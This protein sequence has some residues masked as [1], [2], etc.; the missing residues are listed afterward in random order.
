MNRRQRARLKRH[1]RAP[2]IYDATLQQE[3]SNETLKLCLV[4]VDHISVVTLLKAFFLVLH[5]FV[6]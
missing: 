6:G 3:I 5:A 4:F 1:Q 2:S